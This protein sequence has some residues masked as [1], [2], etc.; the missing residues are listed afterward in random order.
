MEEMSSQG[1]D[2]WLGRID[3]IINL[4]QLQPFKPH[5]SPNTVGNICKE[6]LESKFQIYYLSEINKFK[7]NGDGQNHNKLRFYSSVKGCF[8]PEW[9]IDNI[10]NRNSRSELCRV[11]ISASNLRI[12]RGR[13]TNPPT[14][15]NERT[16]EFCHFAT[17]FQG[18][19]PPCLDDEYHIFFCPTFVNKQRCLFGK[20][21]SIINNFHD[22]SYDEKVKTMLCPNNIQV[23]KLVN[24]YLQ[25]I[26]KC[27]QKLNDGIPM[28][29][30]TYLSYNK[31]N[32]DNSSETDCDSESFLDN[33]PYD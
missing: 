16:C 21:G 25:I 9:Y 11:R 24:K 20:L 17:D 13:Y 6:Q 7:S 3:K 27:R 5:M 2:C 15:L 12:E 19:P 23:G 1:K 32:F 31:F 18:T 33:D 29:Q 4:L 30:L 28:S 14:P 10:H 8:Q 22:L 26:F